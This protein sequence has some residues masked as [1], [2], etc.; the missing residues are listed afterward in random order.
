MD[1]CLFVY[2]AKKYYL[3]LPIDENRTLKSYERK[4][5]GIKVL[6]HALS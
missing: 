2:N 4:G 6:L 5:E 1:V 3:E